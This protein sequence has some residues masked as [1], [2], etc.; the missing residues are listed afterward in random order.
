MLPWRGVFFV[1]QN[2]EVCTGDRSESDIGRPFESAILH[3]REQHHA[4]RHKAAEHHA[5]GSERAA[6]LEACGLGAREGNQQP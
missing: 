1:A 2:E 6:E 5:S 4:P 3:A